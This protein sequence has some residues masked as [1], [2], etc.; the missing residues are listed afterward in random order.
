MAQ[1]HDTT[2]KKEGKCLKAAKTPQPL[3]PTI[4]N[5]ST[6]PIIPALM[7]DPKNVVKNSWENPWT[8]P[9]PTNSKSTNKNKE[10]HRNLSQ[11]QENLNMAPTPLNEQNSGRLHIAD[12]TL[13]KTLIPNRAVRVPGVGMNPLDTV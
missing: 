13:T 9:N 1:T 8:G 12:D 5:T 6:T 2:S 7:A 11:T 3:S 10:K 4:Q